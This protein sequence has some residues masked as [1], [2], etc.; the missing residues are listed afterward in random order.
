MAFVRCT[1]KVSSKR[2]KKEYIWLDRLE[3]IEGNYEDLTLS[4]QDAG[5]TRT[6]SFPL[7]K[8][9]KR[10]NNSNSYEFVNDNTLVFFRSSYPNAYLV[11][12]FDSH[13][14]NGI[15]DVKVFFK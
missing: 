7:A 11:K 4:V 13:G 1:N 3:I 12:I 6:K 10:I 14:D 15:F 2:K 8:W 5:S 9:V